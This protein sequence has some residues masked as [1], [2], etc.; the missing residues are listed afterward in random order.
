MNCLNYQH[1]YYFWV[2][3]KHGGITRASE[4]LG[5]A[6]PTI[7]SQLSTFE[8][9]MGSRLFQ[10]DGRRM[11][12]TYV[13]ER[14]FRY[15][16]QIFKLGE[17][18]HLSLQEARA[19]S[20]RR[21]IIGV[22]ASLPKLVVYRLLSPAFEVGS[23]VQVVCHEDKLERLMP[24]LALHDIDLV[25]SDVPATTAAGTRVYNHLLGQSQIA[26][27]GSKKLGPSYC[28][29]FPVSLNGAPLLLQTTNI[30]LR[31]SLDEW[32]EEHNI[33]PNIVAEIEDS[34][35]LKTFAAEGVGLAIAPSILAN[36]LQR[37]HDLNVIGEL[38]G[39]SEQFYA[40]TTQ[41]KFRN[42]MISA[43]IK[44]PDRTDSDCATEDLERQNGYSRPW[45]MKL[46]SLSYIW[47]NLPEAC[48][49]TA[50]LCL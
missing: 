6:Q 8:R 28:E 1:L 9:N 44:G 14:L 23:P 26:V 29:N 32:F 13:G 11:S 38:E 20:V 36:A 19:L 27:F 12:L 24:E 2:V 5:L 30:A 15:A 50:L 18:I 4:R 10:R 22:V 46:L 34:A 17:E 31:V 25:I 47:L 37:Q 43:I 7:S 21:L 48:E 40:I 33:R 45:L 41:K 49:A 3:A 42:P 35:L 16:D 39:L